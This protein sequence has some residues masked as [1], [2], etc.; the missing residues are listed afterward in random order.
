M[1]NK[2][3]IKNRE[4]Q[5]IS[6]GGGGQ[7]IGVTEV[8]VNG[9][10]VTVGSIAYVVVPTKTSELTNDSGYITQE[11]DPTIPYY[12][13][14]ISQ[15]DINS[16]NNKQNALVS[17]VNIKTINENSILGSGNLDISTSYTAGTG[18]EISEEN[19]ISNTITSYD[20]LT[21][22]PTIPT[23]TSDLTNDSDFVT[24]T[25]LSNVAFSGSYTDLSNKPD[26][27]TL[28]SD[29]ENDSGFITNRVDDLLYYYTKDFMYNLLP[30]VSDSGSTINLDNTY[31]SELKMILD[32]TELSQ[33]STPTPSS[34]QD[35]HTISGDNTIRVC[36]KNLF[37]NTNPFTNN[38][39]NDEGVEQTST[40]TGHFKNNISVKPN[41]QYTM[42]GYLKVPELN[43]ANFARIYF[44]D[45]N[46]NWISRSASI[47]T[48]TSYTFTTPANCYYIN[49]QLVNSSYDIK[50]TN[51]LNT[52]Q[53]ELGSTATT[54][55]AYN[56]T[57]YSVNLGVENLFDKDNPNTL[58]SF[59]NSGYII[60]GGNAK[61]IYIKC[62]PN[63]TYT[64]QKNA[65]KTFRW[66]TTNVVPANNVAVLSTNANH[67]ATNITLT[68]DA[69]ANY[70]WVNYYN[71]DN[72]DTGGE[73]AMMDSIIITKGSHIQQVS[74]TPIEY[75]KIGSYSDRIF[76]NVE[77]DVDYDDTNLEVGLWYIKKN[78]GKVVLDGSENWQLSTTKDITQVFVYYQAM[79]SRLLSYDQFYSNYFI[80][81]AGDTEKLSFA[82]VDLYIAINKTTASNVADFKTWLSTHN[83]DL[84][85]VLSTPTYT[86]ITGTLET[87]LNNLTVNATS[88]T[89]QTNISQINNDLPFT[90]SATTLK[91]LSNL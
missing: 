61:S 81:Q 87:Q 5:Q 19:V 13:K 25:E 44:Y 58:G 16:W 8:L 28:T 1:N 51:S 54:Y 9:V 72:G 29:L 38:W 89:G 10:D 26:I 63:T 83:T 91:D 22:L 47:T 36:G 12:I 70:L 88:Y 64:I 55:E 56:G 6:I 53:L 75:C 31:N 82:G 30:K 80:N 79:N 35:I 2:I 69:T 84:Y 76:K 52:F 14:Q 37:D 18:I 17:G 49:F 3:V 24:S 39:Y 85:Y 7:V 21:D 67:T 50:Y 86:Q 73:T 40:L 60:T 46:K 43:Y 68:T 62:Q 34:P 4:P 57:D 33:D 66:A 71:V 32:P 27:P 45:E 90:I 41:T 23:K 48:Y 65:G 78:I 11:T 42:S 20:D 74:D 59:Y 15:A 77:G